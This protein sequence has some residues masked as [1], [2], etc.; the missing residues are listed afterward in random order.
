MSSSSRRFSSR[1]SLADALHSRQPFP[2]RIQ[3]LNCFFFHKEGALQ[4]FD[5][6]LQLII[7]ALS[8]LSP[9]IQPGL[10]V[11]VRPLIHGPS[12]DLLLVVLVRRSG[13]AVAHNVRPP[14]SPRRI[15]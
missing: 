8:R 10:V 5:L 3:L 1:S 2:S 12:L 14:D 13:F 4:V 7:G 6:C 11:L 15:G 9:E